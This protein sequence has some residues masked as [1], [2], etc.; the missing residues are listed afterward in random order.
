[1]NTYVIE[2]TDKKY[3]EIAP[4]KAVKA[5]LDRVCNLLAVKNVEFS[6]TFCDEEYIH[7]LNREY[8]NIDSPTDILSFAAEDSE[9]GFDFV[10]PARVKRNLGDMIICPEIMHANAE[11]FGITD[12]EEL[13]RL[14]IHGI[15][16]LNGFDHKTN[17]METEPMLIEQEKILR[18]TGEMD[19]N[20]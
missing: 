2:Y 1:M 3:S 7:N 13:S 15:L 18:E 11:T 16:H 19:L 6:V 9:D 8:R 17:D 5:Y 12:N 10:V 20:L 14:L 4:K